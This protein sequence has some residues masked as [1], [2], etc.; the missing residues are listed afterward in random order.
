MSDD[1]KS[2][3]NL[4]LHNSSHPTQTHSIIDK[5]HDNDHFVDEARLQNLILL[6]IWKCLF[7]I[8]LSSLKCVS[9]RQNDIE[10]ALTL[11]RIRSLLKYC[12]LCSKPRSQNTLA[13][14]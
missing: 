7:W 2:Y 12:H 6:Y 4:A 8:L 3:S 13:C 10:I 1:V 11:R 5:Y 9:S 14:K